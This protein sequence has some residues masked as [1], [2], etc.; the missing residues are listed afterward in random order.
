MKDL[1][2]R[3]RV[4]VLKET[5]KWVLTFIGKENFGLIIRTT[6]DIV[7]EDEVNNIK[8]NSIPKIIKPTISSTKN[9]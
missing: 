7:T 5:I 4:N 2:Y 8:A 9:K 1:T 6:L 3:A